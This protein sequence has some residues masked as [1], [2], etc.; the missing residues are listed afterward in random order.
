VYEVPGLELLCNTNE[1]N[2]AYA[3]DGYARIKGAPGVFVTTHGVGELS[4]LNGVVGSLSERIPVI[5]VVGQTSRMLQEKKLMIHHS[6][7]QQPDHQV[8][9]SVDAWMCKIL[10]S[11]QMYNKMSKLGR[12]AEAELWD[13][14]TAPA[15]IDVCSLLFQ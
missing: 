12:I 11:F 4:A 5:H 8:R 2:A 1:L 9:P 3:A 15:E 10:I 14:K 7:G 6:V 13:E